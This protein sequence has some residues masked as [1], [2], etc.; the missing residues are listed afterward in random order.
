MRRDRNTSKN[1][2]E[3][4]RAEPQPDRE[5]RTIRQTEIVAYRANTDAGFRAP[6]RH[7]PNRTRDTHRRQTSH[8][9]QTLAPLA[10]LGASC[11]PFALIRRVFASPPVRQ[12]ETTPAA[13]HNHTSATPAHAARARVG[14]PRPADRPHARAAPG[15]VLKQHQ[16]NPTRHTPRQQD[17]HRRAGNQSRTYTSIE[18][19]TRPGWQHTRTHDPGRD[20]RA[21]RSDHQKAPHQRVRLGPCCWAKRPLFL[22]RPPWARAL[23]PTEGHSDSTSSTHTPGLACAVDEPPRPSEGHGWSGCLPLSA[24]LSSRRWGRRSA[25]TTA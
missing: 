4:R 9:R 23:H 22:S 19:G 17:T 18:S 12:T 5:R 3:Q 21:T 11:R 25:G 10:I 6:A 13:T 7:T 8:R 14:L 15:F 1:T 24:R 16:A 2:S 20:H